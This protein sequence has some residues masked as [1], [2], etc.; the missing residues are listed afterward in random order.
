MTDLSTL[1]MLRDSVKR[2]CS[3]HYNFQQRWAVLSQP[4]GFSGQ[5]WSD[6]AE[7]GWLALRLPEDDGGIEGDA[8]AIGAVMEVVGSH[9]LM[10]PLLASTVLGTGLLLRQGSAD[11]RRAWFPRLAEGSLK[12]AFAHQTGTQGPCLFR[13]GKLY[14]QL[15]N[16]L[17]GDIADKLLVAAQSDGKPVVCVVDGHALQCN[18]YK[19]VDGRSAS[20]V[21]FNAIAA[22]LLGDSSDGAAAAIEDTLDEA[23]VAL[24]AETLGVVSKLV[25]ATNAYLKVRKQFGRTLASN[26]A[27]Q[28]RMVELYLL[29]QEVRALVETAQ[30]ALKLEGSERTRLISGARAFIISAARRIGNEAV[31]MHGGVGVTDELD[32]SHYFRRLMVLAALYGNRDHQ[33]IRFLQATNPCR[34]EAVQ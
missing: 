1:D 24:C 6:Y 20:S 3:E 7:F 28:H 17:H 21:Q 2:Y 32:V 22:E 5:A 29:L 16:V 23:S 26:Q 34:Q 13:G 15:I 19:L 8:K 18:A 12:L 31:Q 25:E 9:L 27:L 11:Q 14:G 33:F 10:E 4:V 30:Y